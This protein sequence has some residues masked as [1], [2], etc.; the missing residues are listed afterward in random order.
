[1]F[2]DVSHLLRTNPPAFHYGVAVT[3][4]DGD[5]RNE[6]VVAGYGGPNRV[7]RFDGEHLWDIAPHSLADAKRGAIG[8]AAADIDGDGKEELYVQNAD[9]NS[10]PKTH[11]DRLFDHD[12]T[13]GQWHDLFQRPENRAAR[14]P[15]SGRSVVALDRRGTGRY[16]FFVANYGRPFRFYEVGT[17]G[18]LTDLAPP[19]GLDLT[20]GGRGLWAG[21]L[22]S[23]RTDILCV[24]ENGRN[25]LLR[26]TGM[27]T[28]LEIAADLR[29]HDPDEHARGVAV[30]DAD[31]DG[32]LD[33]AWGNWEGPH[34]LMIRQADGT[35]RDRATPAMA[36]P[37]TVRTVIAADFDNDGYEE[38]FFH[39]LGEP[40]RLFRY[41]GGE[42]RL[43]DA[44]VATLPD[45][46]GTGAAVADIDGDGRLE[47]LLAHGESAAQPL[48]LFKVT[49]GDGHWLRVAPKTRFG[50][51]A[52]GAVVRL[53]AGERIQTRVIDGGSGYLCQMEPVAHFG[54]G[55]VDRVES[56]RVMWPDGADAV[57]RTPV[58]RRTLVVDY[59]RA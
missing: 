18:R 58:V 35:F 27:G 57:V 48:A 46:T 22:A 59:P 7:L 32:R 55:E 43:A 20:T 56:V 4:I 40:N 13:S 28:F 11:H 16:G 25:F 39:N 23:D 26:N 52:R 53:T 45:G 49:G 15:H 50:A 3:D 8:L 51:P 2:T 44:G 34:R 38:L 30:F 33:V 47:L 41:S 5:G 19:L 24:N 21:P 54:L 1:M 29:L 14:N 37:S 12:P 9:T 6:F 36:L 10:G 31:A 42:W 17:D